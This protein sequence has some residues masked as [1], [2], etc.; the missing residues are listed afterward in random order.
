MNSTKENTVRKE[1]QRIKKALE[2]DKVRWGG[3]YHDS[4]GRRYLPPR[5]FISISDFS[6]ALDYF[7]WFNQTFPDDVG[8]PDFLFE[9]CITL[10]MNNMD[11]EA[12]RMAFRTFSSNI[13]LFDAFFGRNISE[14]NI[15]HSSNDSKIKFA[16]DYFDYSSKQDNLVTFSKWLDAFTQSGVFIKSSNLYIELYGKLLAEGEVSIRSR[17]LKQVDKLENEF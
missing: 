2:A 4:V 10:F 7:R 3:H 5:L 8:S 15:W 17:I 11:R 9:W 14:K 16:T 12:E 1:I 6:G 13:Y